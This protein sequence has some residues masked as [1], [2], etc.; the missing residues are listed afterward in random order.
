MAEKEEILE[1]LR[2]SRSSIKVYLR[3]I[4]EIEKDLGEISLNEELEKNQLLEK[5][6]QLIDD[7]F[8][9][10]NT[11][12][13][14]FCTKYEK[15]VKQK[16]DLIEPSSSAEYEDA[17]SSICVNNDIE[18]EDI[19]DETTT[20]LID[21]ETSCELINAKKKCLDHENAKTLDTVK[22][23][24]NSTHSKDLNKENSDDDLN[25]DDDSENDDFE[26]LNVKRKTYTSHGADKSKT[27]DIEMKDKKQKNSANNE[28]NQRNSNKLKTKDKTSIKEVESGSIQKELDGDEN[29]NSDANSDNI[30]ITEESEM[31]KDKS[32]EKQKLQN[33]NGAENKDSGKIFSYLLYSLFKYI[34]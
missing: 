4:E 18:Q 6:K 30:E 2:N 11:T 3:K 32:S 9:E 22:N 17:V 19:R 10:T 31:E 5:T 20:S 8:R 26:N 13:K 33:S 34:I 21:N 29:I 12:K 23:S 28:P 16:P 25:K 7:I 24:I 1:F 14:V 27:A 15:L